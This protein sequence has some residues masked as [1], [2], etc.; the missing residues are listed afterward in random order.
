MKSYSSYLIYLEL[1]AANE[2]CVMEELCVIEEFNPS[3]SAPLGSQG[4]RA[5]RGHQLL[6]AGSSL[7]KVF[8]V[9]EAN[10]GNPA[11]SLRVEA[12]KEAE[13]VLLINQLS[14]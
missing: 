3:P 12:L 6:E 9:R 10:T 1:C 4:D 5:P 14:R 11:L 2:L 8:L 7:G 13:S